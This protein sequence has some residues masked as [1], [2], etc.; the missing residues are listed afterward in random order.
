MGLELVAAGHYITPP[1][2]VR[3]CWLHHVVLGTCCTFGADKVQHI[4]SRINYT[5]TILWKHWVNVFI[6]DVESLH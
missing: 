6:T 2:V 1:T 5:T 4:A 3:E